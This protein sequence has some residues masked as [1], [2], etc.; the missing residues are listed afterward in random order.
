MA[1]RVFEIAKELGVA[2]KAIV[3]KCQAEGIPEDVIKNHMSSVTA[4]LEATIRE[5]FSGESVEDE[6]HTAVETGAKVD[7]SKAR[8]KPRAKRAKATK[9]KAIGSDTPA[10]DEGGSVAVEE[11]PAST[12]AAPAAAPA[13]EPAPDPKPAK[14]APSG[15]KPITPAAPA[16]ATRVVPPTPT[17]AQPPATA[18]ATGPATDTPTDADEGDAGA[19]AAAATAPSAPTPP[20]TPT[21]PSVPAAPAPM[22]VPVRPTVIKPAGPQLENNDKEKVKLSGPK[23]VRVEAPEPDAGP[24]RGGGGYGGG[25]GGG[26]YGPRGPGMG[27]A[28][29][30][31]RGRGNKRRGGPETAQPAGVPARRKGRADE[32]SGPNKF[33]EADLAERELRLQRS[34]GYLKQRRQAARMQQQAMERRDTPADAGGVVKIQAP[35]NIK[36]LSA[37]T[38]V[39]GA[40]IVKKLFMQGVMATINSGIEVEKAQEIMIDYD[41]ELDV[42]E[43]KSAE[44]QVSAEFEQRDVIDE[45]PRGPVVTIL[46]HVDHGKTSLLDKIRN[47]SVAAG[48]AG[49]ITQATS[50]FRVPV[51]AG[52]ESKNIVFV[53]TPGHEAFTAMRARGASI[54]DIIVLVIAADDGVMPQTIESIAHAKAASVPIVVALNKVDKPEVNDAKIQEVL[55]QLA[56]HELNP[57]A[58]GGD[59]E[60]VKTSAHTGE[61]IQEL[62]DTLDFQSQLLELKAD[63]GGPARGTVIEA[64]PQEGRGV[65]ANILLQDG[66][67][68]V[69]QFIV[70]GR[71]FGRVRD[72]TNDRAKRI[73]EC[74]PPMPVQ[75]SGLDELPDAGDKFYVV[76]SLKK[77]Q[78]AA[79]QRRSREREQ[80]LSQPKVTLD[81][82]LSQMA[83]TDVKE[84]KVVVKADVQGS[85]DVL[86]H[87]IEKVTTEEIRVRVLHAAVGGVTES[88]VVLADASNAVIIGFNVIASSKARQL[89]EQKT[90]E[91]R[92][93][94]VIYHITEDIKKAAEGLLEPE[95]RQEVLGHAEVRE[96]FKVSKVGMIAGC[97][98]TDGVVQRDALI[99]VTRSDIVIENDRKLEQ[100][101]RFKDD[102]KEVRGGMECG[103]KIHAY[104]DIKV[105]DILECYKQVE[106]KRTL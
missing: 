72:M 17:D 96:V 9:A 106:V 78:E 48:E 62:L 54:T 1:R 102:A 35:F 43:A 32:P 19:G 91:I 27:P 87:E 63:F 99:R 42:E 18:P 64:R 57:V 37:V 8:A 26:G 38:G 81:S 21:P 100:L 30:P 28:E 101:K 50:A 47:A 71:A 29:G 69:G 31:S 74:E 45:R 46:G 13:A 103:M 92:N 98:V 51:T 89:A 25:G 83:E 94:Q 97:Y 82:M 22:N 58:W 20:A 11:P 14:P 67:L 3:A 44:E 84:I 52:E 49:G 60:V 5:W 53:D 10:A 79:E 61:G 36:E 95:L 2:S 41:I 88:D 90:V 73:K 68:K 77:A 86:K 55:G 34:G 16:A 70:C 40:D 33:S 39:K 4:G 56:Q 6:P 75:I 66:E 85:V 15:I 80:Q 76:N 93:Y 23:V 12:P 65:V 105:G 7:L 24:R 59:V 104:D